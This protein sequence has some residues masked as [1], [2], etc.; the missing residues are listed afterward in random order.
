M[1]SKGVDV[2]FLVVSLAAGIALT[3]LS[4]LV[5]MVT[6]VGATRYGFPLTWMSRLVL[7]PEHYP[8]RFNITYFI[9]DAVIWSF[10]I[11]A[12]RLLISRTR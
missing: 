8:W 11:A 1:A 10:I 4:G 5:P 2:R 12:A 9:V 6:L 3:V 7:A